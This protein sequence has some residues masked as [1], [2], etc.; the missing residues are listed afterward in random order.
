MVFGHGIV[1]G[2]AQHTNGLKPKTDQALKAQRLGS[3]SYARP[4]ARARS[5]SPEPTAAAT[6]AT[7]MAGGGREWW[8]DIHRGKRVPF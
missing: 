1:L 3:L 2:Q 7:V 5:A 4:K 6:P 8:R